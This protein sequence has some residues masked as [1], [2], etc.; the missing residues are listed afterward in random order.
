[1]RDIL[2]DILKKASFRPADGTW[3]IAMNEIRKLA[4][5]ALKELPEDEAVT[6]AATELSTLRQPGHTNIIDALMVS[7]QA[8]LLAP[9][10]IGGNLAN[11]DAYH[12]A[13]AQLASGGST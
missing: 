13:L 6:A 11:F 8:H 12:Q 4:E 3:W 2:N 5:E 9:D 1:M 7:G 10:A